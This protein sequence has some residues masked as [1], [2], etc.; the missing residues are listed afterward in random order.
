MEYNTVYVMISQLNPQY[1]QHVVQ[2]CSDHNQSLIHLR[3]PAQVNFKA[4]VKVNVKVN[5]TAISTQLV[6]IYL[7]NLKS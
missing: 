2:H 6:Q 1:Q 7:I 4:N 3:Q 5:V